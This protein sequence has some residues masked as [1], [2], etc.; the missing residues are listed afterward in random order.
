MDDLNPQEQSRQPKSKTGDKEER[1]KADAPEPVLPRGEEH[2]ASLS[3]DQEEPTGSTTDAN[4]KGKKVH[5]AACRAVYSFLKRHSAV[6]QS[7]GVPVLILIGFVTLLIAVVTLIKSSDGKSEPSEDQLSLLPQVK[8]S[9]VNTWGPEIEMS[10]GGGIVLFGIRVENVGSRPVTDIVIRAT[11]SSFLTEK[12]EKCRYGVERAATLP[13]KGDP[14]GKSGLTLPELKPGSYAEV[15]FVG[16]LAEDAPRSRY[17]A[18]M[19][20]SSGRTPEVRNEAV[21]KVPATE[22]ENAVRSLFSQTEEGEPQFW[23]GT[24]IV[25]QKSKRLLIN[26]WPEFTLEKVHAFKKV[27]GGHDVSVSGLFFDHTLEGE[28]LLIQGVISG[29]P[30]S[31]SQRGDAVK[32]SYE[33]V[34]RRNRPSLVCYTPRPADQLLHAGEEIELKAIPIA[35]SPSGT[36]RKATMAVCPAVRVARSV[37]SHQGSDQAAK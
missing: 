22:A 33:V 4:K 19:V 7:A 26:Q 13:C 14:L 23:E 29:H 31:L 27:P 18:E 9:G 24:P 34:G 28:L 16:E 36:T 2:Q 32:Q 3:E 1:R 17:G 6:I 20:V 10:S 35:W 30:S 37:G 5:W 11:L 8:Q 12:P 25:A 21:I 15:V